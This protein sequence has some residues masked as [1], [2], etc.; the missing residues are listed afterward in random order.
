M[1]DTTFLRDQAWL[2]APETRAVMTALG[3]AR[4]VG[5]CVR[6][7]LLGAPVDD[8]D[9]A[10]P[11]P[12]DEVA[13]RVQEAGLR[14]VDTGV[15]HGT[16]TVISNS[17]PYEVTTLRR[18][19]TTD[20]RRAVVAFTEDWAEDAARRDFTMNALY[21]DA[22]GRVHDH[23]HG[24]ADLKAR[25]VRF[26]GEASQRIAEDY[27]RVLRFFRIHAWYG[28]G[29]LDA[30][31]LSACAAA[32]GRLTSLSGERIQKEMLKLFAAR[33][34]LPAVTAMLHA[35]IIQE[36]VPGTL[37]EHRFRSLC[38]VDQ[39]QGFGPDGLLRLGALLGNRDQA[40]V[41]ASRWRLSNDHRDRLVA[42]FSSEPAVR[43]DMTDKDFGAVLYRAGKD[44][45]IDHIRLAWAAAGATG[46]WLRLLATA[47]DWTRPTFPL[48]GADIMSAGVPQGPKV[49]RVMSDVEQWWID[50]GFVA[51]RQAVLGKMR[52]VIA[53]LG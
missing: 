4:F 37:S 14:A 24:L 22:D 6:N 50:G 41:I 40:I 30:T 28:Q 1:T 44:A 9:I 42:M 46:D 36:L 13:R 16:V 34:P 7:A 52:S 32:K 15:E 20:G 27:L 10:T 5:G 39:A 45:V 12:P 35:G 17:R 21:A 48:S 33:D 11:F 29:A 49:G 19:V 23:V 8:I 26:I 25:R 3:N 38:Q 31:G 53:A 2:N 43:E 18:D 47:R 51:D